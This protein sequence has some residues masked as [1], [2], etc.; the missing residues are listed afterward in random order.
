[1]SGLSNLPRDH[2]RPKLQWQRTIGI[3]CKRCT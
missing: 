1:M 3:C 2:K